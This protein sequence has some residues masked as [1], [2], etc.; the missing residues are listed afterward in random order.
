MNFR[1]SLYAFMKLG[2]EKLSGSHIRP[3]CDKTRKSEDNML[4]TSK[5]DADNKNTERQNDASISYKLRQYPAVS[6]ALGLDTR[7]I[8]ATS[9]YKAPEFLRALH[10][11]YSERL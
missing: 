8:A 5:D 3:T 10:K 11:P 9:L 2:L 7:L 1:G 6:S 4:E